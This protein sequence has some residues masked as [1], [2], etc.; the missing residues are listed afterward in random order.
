MCT[1]RRSLH[2]SVHVC[3]LCGQYHFILVS[4]YLSHAMHLLRSSQ[5]S[6]EISTSLTHTHS[7]WLRPRVCTEGKHECTSNR[8]SSVRCSISIKTR[9][10]GS[11]TNNTAT[12]ADAN[13]TVYRVRRRYLRVRGPPVRCRLRDVPR[14]PRCD[15]F[16][17][18]CARIPRQIISVAVA[19]QRARPTSACRD[20]FEN[21]RILRFC[22]AVPHRT[23]LFGKLFSHQLD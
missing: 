7:C 8:S 1:V 9:T 17:E 22:A 18:L 11:I 19:G 3:A 16:V 13:V 12:R 20:A 5:S 14:V 23:R 2:M 6:H 15:R 4:I 10:L 21:K